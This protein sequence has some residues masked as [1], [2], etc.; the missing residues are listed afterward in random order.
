[1]AE[2]LSQDEI[3]AL[4]DIAEQ[5]DD[6]DGTN[7]LD[8]FAAKE[9]SFT[10]YDFKKPNRVTLDQLKAL[11]TMHDKMLRE[12]TNDL[13]SMLRKMVDV[14]LMSIEQMTYGEFILSIP[15]VTSLSTLSMKPL[16]GRI[17]IECNP[18]ISH[19]VIADLLG[20][21]AVNTMDSIDRELTEIEIKILEHFYR[22]FIKI[23]Y[24]TWSD[25]SSLNFKIE[26]SD[27]NANAIQIVSDHD[28]VLLVV[29]EITIDEDSGFLSICYPI[30]YIEPLLNKIV[31]KIFSEGKNTKLSRKQDIKTLISGARMKIEPIMAE[32]EMSTL[33]ILNLKEGDIIVFNKNAESNESIVY[34]NKKE[35]FL[36]S[37][38][39][40]NNRKAIELLSNLDKEKQE[41]L[42]TLRLM[43]EEREQKAKENAE[44][45]K[46]LLSERKSSNPTIS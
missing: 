30:S 28:I 37:C 10:I 4:L 43:R 22:M 18:T 40:S 24:K 45:I 25:V 32:T 42:E 41:T 35:K 38:G 33:E 16:D 6:I 1:M 13:S 44:N 9:K 23:L 27:T 46:K 15:Q 7:P 36:A 20:S 11:T 29:F 12:F 26:S 3:D 19:K 17:V 21:G 5:G 39:I 2:F 34:V 8:K 14:K 31:D